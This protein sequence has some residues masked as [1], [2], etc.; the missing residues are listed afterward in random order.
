MLVPLQIIDTSDEIMS[1]RMTPKRQIATTYGCTEFTKLLRS[2]LL[3]ISFGEFSVKM[4]RS[5]ANSCFKSISYSQHLSSI[6]NEDNCSLENRLDLK[7]YWYLLHY[8]QNHSRSAS[9]EASKCLP[10]RTW[11]AK[12]RAWHER[13]KIGKLCWFENIPGV[14]R[15]KEV[16]SIY[17]RMT[18]SS[19]EYFG[20]VILKELFVFKKLLSASARII[21]HHYYIFF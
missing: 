16:T 3:R 7:P 5:G 4:L 21:S 11:N 12:K 14:Q 15:G 6:V 2:W 18:S 8:S 9:K 19:N 13:R 17:Y 10:S 20:S 1:Y